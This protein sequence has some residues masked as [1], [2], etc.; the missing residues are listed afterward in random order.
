MS[1]ENN[2][3]TVPEEEPEI[4]EPENGDAAEESEAPHVP[5]WPSLA[6]NYISFIGIAISLAALVSIVLLFLLEITGSTDQPYLGILIYILFPSVLILGLFVI[7]VGMFFERRRRRKVAAGTIAEFPILDLN[8]PRRRRSLIVFMV[9]AFIFMFMS[10][11]GAYHAYEFTES[12][13]FCGQVCH[14]VMKPE[15]VSY[16][17][18]PHAQV[19]CVECHVGGGAEWYARSKFSGVRQLVKVTFNTYDR[20]IKTPVENMRPARDTCAKCHWPQLYHGEQLKVFTDYGYDENS[21][22]SETKLLV[23][24]GGGSPE[25]G[26]VAGI[27]WHMNLANEITY[28][29]TDERRQDIPWVQLKD[30]K[31]NVTVYTKRGSGLS[32]SQIASAEKKTMDCIDCHSR[33]AHIYRSPNNAVDESIQANKLDRSL[34]FLKRTAVEVLTGEYETTE[35]ALATIGEEFHK[36]YRVNHAEVYDKQRPAI[37]A[38][39]SELGRIYRTYFFPEMKTDWS[40]HIDNIGH[41]NTQGCFRCHDGEHFSPAGKPIR[42]EC[43]ICH[44]TISQTYLGKPIEP[45]DG[46]FQHPI[47][48]GERG[49]YNCAACHTGDR[50]FKHP[51]NLGDISRFSCNE[52]H[53]EGRFGR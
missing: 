15:F 49:N 30:S 35:Q 48:L 45:I 39:V 2:G 24:V 28:I 1:E 8:D 5:K 42:N 27:H 4:T 11:F 37:N 40:T 33:P 32:A 23:K 36:Y 31:G 19:N 25:T 18:S 20:P 6:R 34:P 9:F 14:E 16:N 7:A 46:K 44:V 22:M 21:T 43:N 50:S 47:N 17:A 29:T 53:K 51:V 10:A 13:T 41:F 12:V 26:Q 3:N 52:C 38:A